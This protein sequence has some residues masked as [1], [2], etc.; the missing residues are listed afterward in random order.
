MEVEESQQLSQMK[1]IVSKRLKT[2]LRLLSFSSLIA[3][4][5]GAAITIRVYYL[6]GGSRK[7]LTSWLQTAAWPLTL[8]PLAISYFYRCRLS[9]DAAAPRPKLCLSSRVVFI[10]GA[11]LGLLMGLDD[12]FYAYG[13]AYLPVSTSSIIVS[14]QLAFTS[15]FA[16]AIVKQR[17]T[18]YSL[19]AVALLIAGAV[20]LGLAAD[21]DRPPGE[22]SKE[23][24]A[25]F[26]M[27]LAA[28]ALYGLV[29]PLVEL[30]Y[31]KAAAKQGAVSYTLA[32][33]LQLLIGI[34]ATALCTVGMIA[35]N[36][37]QAMRR[38]GKDFGLGELKYYMVLVWSA[39]LCELLLLGTI[40]T[41]FYDSALLA[42][43]I[44]AVCLPITEV[45]AVIFLHEPFSGQK[46]VAL[47]LSLWGFASYFYGEYKKGKEKK[48]ETILEPTLE[49]SAN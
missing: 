38:E 17:F 35:N 4:G 21:G 46:G 20:L 44:L 14:S 45:F 42:G 40:G 28:A 25:G 48:N 30:T 1:P 3:G 32:M 12:F 22:S 10:A 11:V 5:V 6:H 43:I 34:F 13:A 2:T 36:D 24:F 8:L 33:E 47:A 7:W 18:A 23:Y 39:I 37:F 15:P 26:F 41:I 27:M 9:A 49:V 29:L 19:N 16:F 31:A